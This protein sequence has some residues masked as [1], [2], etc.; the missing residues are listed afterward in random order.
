MSTYSFFYGYVKKMMCFKNVDNTIYLISIL[1]FTFTVKLLNFKKMNI[2]IINNKM[3]IHFFRH[4]VC[5]NTYTK[6][7][8]Q[9]FWKLKTSLKKSFYEQINQSIKFLKKNIVFLFLVHQKYP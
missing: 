6:E 4:L 9:K 5:I 7:I 1:A 3:Y 8:T 2:A